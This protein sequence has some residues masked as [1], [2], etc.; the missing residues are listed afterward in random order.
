MASNLR[1]FCG[2]SIDAESTILP[3]LS[4]W[5]GEAFSEIPEVR[6]FE[7]HGLVLWGNLP[8]AGILGASKYDYLLTCISNLLTLHKRNSICVL[9]HPNRAAQMFGRTEIL[10][11]D[12]NDSAFQSFDFRFVVSLSSFFF[13]NHKHFGLLP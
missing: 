9:V 12:I 6:S 8:T 7:D 2:K 1:L 11:G 4:S 3:S 5:I 13:W 10:I